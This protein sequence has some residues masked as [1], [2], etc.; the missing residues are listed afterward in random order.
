MQ[1]PPVFIYLQKISMKRILSAVSAVLLVVGCATRS[2]NNVTEVYTLQS[3][4]GNMEMKFQLTDEGV[5]QYCLDYEDREVILPSGLGFEL[6][7]VLKAQQLVYGPDGKIFKEDC[8][9]PYRFNRDFS[10][11]GIET[12]SFDEIWNPVWGEEAQIRNHYNELLVNLSHNLTGRKMSV[13]FRLFDDG[14]GFR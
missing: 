2:V 3:P 4:S 6:R 9:S 13:R 8:E 11:E 14:L 5:P 10:V 7:A 12:D 1:A